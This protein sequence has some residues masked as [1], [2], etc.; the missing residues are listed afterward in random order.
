MAKKALY[1]Y[2]MFKTLSH[3]RDVATKAAEKLKD[4]QPKD[5]FI[6]SVITIEHVEELQESSAFKQALNSDLCNRLQVYGSLSVSDTK[7]FSYTPRIFHFSSTQ[8]VFKANELYSPLRCKDLNTPYPFTQSQLY[9]ARQPTIFMI[10]DGDVLWL[11]MGWWPLEDIKISTEERSS[12]TNENRAGVN[13]W[14]SERRAA[15]ET[16]VS[17]WRAKFGDNEE[18]QFHGIKGYVAWAGLECTAFKALFPEWTV[19]EDV[20]EINLQVS[21][22]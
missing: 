9:N 10:D 4:S 8:G 15:L 3:T 13:R 20:K 18:K 21:L 2:G 11:W 12:P 6:S 22:H 19:R 17:Y 5:L 7:D 1:M 16:A 14:I